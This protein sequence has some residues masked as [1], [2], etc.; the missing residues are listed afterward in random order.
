ML[1]SEIIAKN[2]RPVQCV[3]PRDTVQDAINKMVEE[4][5]GS[6]LVVDGGA[7]VG[8]LT[9]R[10]I[11]RESATWGH[12]R[13]R[14]VVEDLMTANVVKGKPSD[15]VD[16]LLATMTRHR[17]RHIPILEGARIEGMV[18]LGD[19]VA[20]KLDEVRDENHALKE[21]ITRPQ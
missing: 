13:G 6:V 17:I 4:R 1:I 15:T 19:L 14:A 8:I 5:I 12:L 10:D 11:L 21:Y 7:M 18:S 2:A 16:A 3:G 9:E 20:S